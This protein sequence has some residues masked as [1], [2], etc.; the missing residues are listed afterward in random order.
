MC[1]DYVQWDNFLLLSI[2]VVTWNFQSKKPIEEA[3]EEPRG[4]IA[5]NK[6]GIG[7]TFN[8]LAMNE[9]GVGKEG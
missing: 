6:M 5:N 4:A 1:F 2:F 3:L 7:P 8:L 9:E